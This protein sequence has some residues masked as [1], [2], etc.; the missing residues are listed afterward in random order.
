[1]PLFHMCCLKW[2]SHHISHLMLLEI[3]SLESNQL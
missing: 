3:H 2:T 1:L